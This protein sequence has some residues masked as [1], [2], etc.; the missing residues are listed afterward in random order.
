MKKQILAAAVTAAS[1]VAF[2]SALAA[3]SLT[4]YGTARFGLFSVSPGADGADSYITAKKTAGSTRWGI[5]GKEDLGHGLKAVFKVETS[6]GQALTESVGAAQAIGDRHSYVGLETASAGTFLLG[7]T[8]DSVYSAID[9]TDIG[10]IVGGSYSHLYGGAF[11]TGGSLFW[12]SPNWGG[13]KVGVNINADANSYED[14]AFD[15]KEPVMAIGL[16]YS[17]G[18]LNIGLGHRK[19]DKET[20]T[21]ERSFN[22]TTSAITDT[23]TAEFSEASYTAFAVN[24]KMDLGGVSVTPY[25]LYDTLETDTQTETMTVVAGGTPTLSSENEEVSRD[26]YALGARIGLSNAQVNIMFGQT[27]DEDV[28]GVEKA[29]SGATVIAAEYLH[30]LSKRTKVGV[31]Y[32]QVKSDDNASSSFGSVGETDKEI[33]VAVIHSF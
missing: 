24:Y 18:A 33:G 12:M 14:S 17:A 30:N 26:S 10:T 20:I 32:E 2:S 9:F 15:K 29:D 8:W 3:D 11:R 7:R 25:I 31:G 1:V 4:L 21:S 13:L 22:T 28:D 5:T 6:W 27:Q 23:D 16:K 19:K